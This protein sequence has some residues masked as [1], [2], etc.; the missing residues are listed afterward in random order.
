MKKIT[1]SLLLFSTLL[2]TSCKEEI[3]DLKNENQYSDATY[4]QSAPQFNE[5]VVGTYSVLLQ[6]GLW[7]R[8]WYFIADLL[9]NDAERDAPL[10]GDLLQFHDF[11]YE[12]SQKQLTDLWRTLYRMILRANLVVDKA[13]KWAPTTDEEKALRTQYIGEARFLKGYAEFMLVNLWGR[14]PLKADFASSSDLFTPRSSVA[15]VWKAVEADLTAAADALPLKYTDADRGRATKG[16]AIALLGKSLLYQKKYPEAAT[17][18]EKLRTAPF[19]YK[20]ESNYDLLFSDENSGNAE[21]IFDVPHLWGGWD[22]GNA[23][24]MFG[25]QEAWG[26]KATHSGRAMEYGWND[27]R[28]V[29]ISDAAVRSFKYKDETG[30]DYVDPRGKLTFYGDAASGGDAD[31]CNACAGGA[32]PYP[33]N[34]ANGYRFRKYHHYEAKEKEEQPQSNIN[35]QVVRYADVLLM[36]AEAYV[37]Q[38]QADKALP[39][40]NQ[41]RSRVK[42]FEYKTLGDQAAARALV[43]RERQLELTGEQQRWFDLNR[44]GVAQQVIN[45]EKQLQIG[46]QPFQAKHVLFPIP[47]LEKDTNP[48]V[49]GDV[50]SGWN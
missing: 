6:T 22:K 10:L 23:Y 13:G 42:A 17:Q 12:S 26:G 46:K 5:A 11:S 16:A 14:V 24:Y 49:A 27:W 19:A 7:S 44:W 43:R 28:N 31:Y 8:D 21:T 29:F 38:G 4:F 20:L 45:A 33:Y 9:G 30:K 37:E 1:F 35:S 34:A 36:L 50:N 25:G 41:V 3:L 15:D 40:V 39:L 47:Q 48:A 32:K 18:L 2:A